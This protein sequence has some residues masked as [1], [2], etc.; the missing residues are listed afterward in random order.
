MNLMQVMLTQG[1][2]NNKVCGLPLLH[3]FTRR[4]DRDFFWY[5]R[6]KITINGQ[7]TDTQAASLQALAQEL[8]LPQKGVAIAV[9]NRMVPRTE[10]ETTPLSE[11][12]DVV[13]I[14]AAFGG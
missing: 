8:A 1:L 14:K 9:S 4:G 7:G 12:A 11:G 2:S 10:W 3:P 5:I 6:M 13:I